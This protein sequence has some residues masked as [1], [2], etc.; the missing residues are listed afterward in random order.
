MSQAV[1]YG[2]RIRVRVVGLLLLLLL[3]VRRLLLS[4]ECAAWAQYRRM[5]RYRVLVAWLL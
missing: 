2:A 4:R 1:D 5:S 3:L